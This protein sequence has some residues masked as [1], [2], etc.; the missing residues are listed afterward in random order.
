VIFAD[1]AENR[2]E[3]LWID[4]AAKRGL[5]S[6]HIR[7]R[8]SNWRTPGGV[9]LGDDLRTLERLNRR[10][11]RL[12]GF[13]W[14]YGGTQVSWAGGRLEADVSSSCA[15]R[16]RLRPDEHVDYAGP[17]RQVVG[18]REFSPGH[19]AMQVINPRVY[20]VWLAFRRAQ[21]VR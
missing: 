11:F 8:K 21:G 3:V 5:K 1:S 18:S 16:V 17:Y 10:P 4:T 6:V 13:G 20:E 7:G 12:M 19:P 15:V 2:V 14:D 9:S